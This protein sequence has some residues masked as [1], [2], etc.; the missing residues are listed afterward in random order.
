[1]GLGYGKSWHFLPLRNEELA[2]QT[3]P[4]MEAVDACFPARWHH[5]PA[6][7]HSLHFG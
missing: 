7:Q 4:S 1:M 5:P 3:P 2:L 6:L